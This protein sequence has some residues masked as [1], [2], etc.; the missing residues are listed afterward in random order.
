MLGGKHAAEPVQQLEL[1]RHLPDDV[2]HHQDRD[3][4]PL[5]VRQKSSQVGE[6]LAFPVQLGFEEAVLCRD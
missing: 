5:G 3:L 1:E 4:R 2:V 6:G